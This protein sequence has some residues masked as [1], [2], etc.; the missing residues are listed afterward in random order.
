MAFHN[1]KIEDVFQELKTGGKGLTEEEAEKR[2]NEFGPNEIADDNK[3]SPLRI[4]FEQFNSFIVYI[5]IAAVIISAALGEKIDTIVIGII[6]ILNAVLGFVQEYRAE[7]S[8][9]ALKKMASLR[10]TV[11]RNG[12]EKSLDATELV[13]G[14]IIILETGVI[15]PADARLIDL[16]NL[17]TQEAALTG[18]S[19]PVKKR[20]DALP[21]KTPVADMTNMIL[22]GTIITS[23]RGRAVCT[24]TGMSTEIG[25]I[26]RLIQE[27]KPEPTHLQK[28]LSE[29]GRFLGILTIAICAIVLVGGVLIRKEPLLE[30]FI[31]AISL[32]V[33]AI[34]EGLPAVV[35]I[36]LALGVQR[37]IKRN[38]LI[39]KLP[40]VE[41]LGVTTVICSDKTGTL[42]KNEMTVKKIYANGKIIDV[43]GS[44]YNATGSFLSDG[45]RIDMKEIDYLLTIGALNNDAKLTD[46]EVFG[47]PTEGALI[48]SAKKAG[49]KIEELANNYK[50][51][52]EA[53]FS[54]ERKLMTTIHQFN[55]EKRAFIKGAPEIVLELCNSIYENGEI[56]KL[57]DEKKNEIHRITREFADSALRV[58]GFAYKTVI[59]EGSV[60][61]D[62]IFVGLEAMIDPPRVEIKTSIEKCRS[63]G[64][65]VVMITGDFE[66][67]AKSIAKEIGLEGKILTGIDLDK[68]KNLD[69]IVEDVSIYAR[70]NP[71]HKIKIVEALKKKGHIVAMTG[72]GVNDA[73]ALKNADIGVSMGITGTDVAKESS[74]M[75]LTDDNFSS[76]VNA[77][78][79][80]RGIYDNIRKFVEYLLSTNTGEVL[81]IFV[82]ILIGLPVPLIAIMILW[83]N[84]VTDGLPA[85]ALSVDPHD[86]EIMK[87]KPRKPKEH[88]IT[89]DMITKIILV[90]TVM[91]LGALWL[92]HFELSS[93]QE[94]KVEDNKIVGDWSYTGSYFDFTK[95]NP[96]TD[97]TNL[98]EIIEAKK[99]I[100][101]KLPMTMTFA[102]LV[103]FQMFI[104]LN[105]R[106]E[107]FF[108]RAGFYRNKYLIGA[109]TLSILLQ[110]LVIHTPLNI[111]FKTAPLTLFDWAIVIMVSATV[112]AAAEI[113]K[114]IKKYHKI[115]NNIC[116]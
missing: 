9:E 58:L 46:G 34:P 95:N 104:C 96:L 16:A 108:F 32:A 47:D 50:R 72:D 71:E 98:N 76:I 87:R 5:L 116:V 36:G 13:P 115:N 54:S 57:S 4:F 101:I 52:D 53:P 26:A 29:L 40:S 41:T 3:I 89:K 61:K 94:I 93:V 100:L 42:T 7:K 33:A 66:L 73:P 91:M 111:Y 6:L 48:V 77:V 28:R 88:I 68:T 84:L 67:T 49:L 82:A 59:D 70:V 81:T 15:V 106:T 20:L 105:C 97:N 64:I 23:G 27:V 113:Y 10:A 2:L 21:E 103:M 63:A 78:E 109:V 37:M 19:M 18:E 79:E 1:K 107:E 14:D 112:L 43:T 35:T 31:V 22:S 38:A 45:K 25:K 69:E 90:G 80:G 74:N 99:D 55:G 8:I 75:I 24:A 39:R 110:I 92:F 60:E 11:I 65:K 83:M 12:R 17:E 85:L 44:G 114:L 56:I 62:L 86:K 102:A 30:M 51:I